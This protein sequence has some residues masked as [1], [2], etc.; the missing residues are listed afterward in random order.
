MGGSHRCVVVVVV[1][2]TVLDC[3]HCADVWNRLLKWALKARR[4]LRKP[5]H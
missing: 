1:V 3:L 2:A 5:S 4:I